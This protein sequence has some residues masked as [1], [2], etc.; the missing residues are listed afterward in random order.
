MI[1]R[2]NVRA[3][4]ES[5]VNACRR[6]FSLEVESRIV[7][8]CMMELGIA[9][10]D[11]TPSILKVT[12]DNIWSSQ[13]KK[14]FIRGLAVKMCDTYVLDYEKHKRFISACQH[15]DVSANKQCSDMTAEGRYKC[16]YPGCKRTFAASGQCRRTHEAKHSPPL[17]V[18]ED[19]PTV[20]L[21]FED[22]PLQAD[23]MYNYQK[24]LMEMGMLIMNIQDAISEGDGSRVL[25]CWKFLLL[26]LKHDNGST[27]YSV[28]VLY[29]MFQINAILSPRSAHQLIWNRFTK[30]RLGPAGHIPLDLNL[31]F[32]NKTVKQAV[33][34]LGSNASQK[35]INR[36]CHSIDVTKVLM[37]NFDK[38][39]KTYKT[40]GKH[41]Q[42]SVLKDM[43]AVVAEL[44]DQ[45][46]LS[47]IPGRSYSYY[48]N[49]PSSI[50]A[51]FDLEK[52]YKWIN[53]HKKNITVGRRAR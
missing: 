44:L 17:N 52:M 47:R 49:A 51:G 12:D 8:A 26:Y 24:S 3:D 2:R 18:P 19:N 53:D 31:E 21:F 6:F 32:Y 40:S 13:Q 38:E 9:D 25:R 35:S 45:K 50:L 42:Q 14:E 48:A 10:F 39:V 23:D 28:E 30:L 36:I 33:K 43:K 7:A 46:A 15:A 37:E 16:R 34:K 41:V 22:D 20:D 1:N 27:K 29:M 5:N 4:V 11:D